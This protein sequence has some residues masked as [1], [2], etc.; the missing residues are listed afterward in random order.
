[1]GFSATPIIIIGIKADKLATV[2]THKEEWE[3]HDERTGEP[4][5]EM[6]TDEKTTIK[7]GDNVMNE[8]DLKYIDVV[9]DLFGLSDYIKDGEISLVNTVYEGVRDISDYIIGVA[10]MEVN[11]MRVDEVLTSVPSHE[12]EDMINKVKEM[13]TVRFGIETDVEVFLHANISY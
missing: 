7:F 5:G 9:G 4:T 11:A 10:V 3:K 8:G 12:F 2:E 1:M 13:I 6:V